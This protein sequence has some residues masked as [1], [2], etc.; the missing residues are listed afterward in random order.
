MQGVK[1]GKG[2]YYYFNQSIYEG[3]WEKDKANGFGKITF[4]NGD[5]YEGGFI[6]GCKHG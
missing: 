6:N 1:H 3:D 5:F 4:S 2:T